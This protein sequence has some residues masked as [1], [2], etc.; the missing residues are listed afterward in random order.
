MEGMLGLFAELDLD[1]PG[2]AGNSLGGRIALEAAAAGRAE[3]VRAM[4]LAGFWRN[5]GE[6]A[7]ARSVDRAMEFGAR[8]FRRL[9]PLLSRS[10]AGRALIYADIVSRPSRVSPRQ[11]RA[12]FAAFLAAR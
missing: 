12:D 5:S 2:L 8:M 6:L 9:G 1:R 7:Y 10:T 4:S 11:A 3:S